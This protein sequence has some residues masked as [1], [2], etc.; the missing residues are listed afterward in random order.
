MPTLILQGPQLTLHIAKQTA[1]QLNAELRPQR[2]HYQLYSK[3]PVLPQ[4]LA[5]LR[6][7]YSVDINLLPAHCPPEQIRLFITDM[8][9][10]FINIECINEI[11]AYVDKEAQVSAITAA[12]M[13]GEINFESS[14]MQRVKLLTG[15]SANVLAEIYEKRLAV[16]PGGEALLAALKQ[17]G[18][19]IALVSGGFT[20][21]TERLKQ[22]Y[23][24]D[25]ALANQLEIKDDR[26]TGTVAGSVVGAT[27]KASF[28]RQL[29][30]ELN[31]GLEQTIAI[32]DGANDLEMLK[33]AGLSV[34]YHAKP[35]VQAEACVV[36]NHSSL[37]GILPFLL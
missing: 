19:K 34:A 8:D 5:M 14:L 17:R 16:N 4:T 20:Y 11:A 37:D 26:L 3:Q 24:L 9:S 7:T 27:A 6:A 2:Q 31:I 10:T 35:K 28:L 1:Q 33:I 15:V 12:A 29:C 25:Y 13:R 18:I 22:Q 21:F 23:N 30:K 32:G 36:L